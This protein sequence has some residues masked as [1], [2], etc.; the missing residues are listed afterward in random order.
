M[1]LRRKLFVTFGT[2]VFLGLLVVG[3]S[4][5]ATFQWRFTGEQLQRHYTCSLEAQQVQGATFRAPKEVSDVLAEGD[6]NARQEFDGAIGEVEEDL[7]TWASLADTEEERRQVEEVRAAYKRVVQDANEVFDLVEAGRR[8]DALNLAERRLEVQQ[9]LPPQAPPAPSEQPDE[10]DLPNGDEDPQEF[11]DLQE[12]DFEEDEDVEDLEGSGREEIQVELV[13][14]VQGQPN[15]NSFQ[16]FES[17]T[18]RAIASDL[19]SREEVLAQTQNTRRTAQLVLILAAFGTLSLL[20][21]LAAYLA[22]DLFRP[23]RELKLA[24]DGVEKG[25]LDRRLNEDR[26]DELGEISRSFNR[27]MEAISR[28]EG[29]N[30]LAV[31]AAGEGGDEDPAAW[32]NSPSR[33]TLHRLVSQLRS[34]I[35]QLDDTGARNGHTTDRKEL[36]G[37]L[38]GLSQAVARITDF[39]FPLDLNLSRTDMRALLYRVFMR[40]QDEFSERAVSIELDIA[41]EVDHAV[42]DRLKLREA[43]GELLR[44]ALSALPEAGGRLGLRSRISEDGTVLLIEVADDGEGAE[45]SLID[46]AFDPGTEDSNGKPRVGLALTRA[47]VEQHGGELDV[48]SVPGGGTYA[49][50]RLPLRD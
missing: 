20:L 47:I 16:A 14:F 33:V 34:K 40:F 49:G 30:G 18:D 26:A 3:V 46:E 5:W 9:D 1:N 29:T 48:E 28:R 6:S 12:D 17:A 10:D 27:A 4:I 21:L 22:S 8:Q 2:L 41:P 36:V 37:Q 44:N 31:T 35:T 32:R 38:E 19:R 7:D 42:V 23:L 24:L 45:Q 43:V 11:D 15:E 50:I 39:G 25:D 13:G